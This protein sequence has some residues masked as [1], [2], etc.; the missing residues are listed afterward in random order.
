MVRY[1]ADVACGG[2]GGDMVQVRAGG[3][4]GSFGFERK[5]VENDNNAIDS[6]N[7]EIK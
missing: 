6:S 5:A 3:F 4:G 7:S 1:G 2:G